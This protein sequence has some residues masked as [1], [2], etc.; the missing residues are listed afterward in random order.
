MVVLDSGIRWWCLTAI[1]D[2][3]TGRSYWMVVE[4]DGPGWWYYRV[5]VGE[6]N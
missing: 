6:I 4:D 1:L 2:G 3:G 5:V